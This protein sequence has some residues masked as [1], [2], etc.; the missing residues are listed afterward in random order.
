MLHLLI[1]NVEI[2]LKTT[3]F[4]HGLLELCTFQIISFD[5]MIRKIFRLKEEDE[6]I[7]SE[8]LDALGYTSSYFVVNMGNVLMLVFF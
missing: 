7:V 1:A 2:P 4:M 8:N 5:G 6:V 3:I